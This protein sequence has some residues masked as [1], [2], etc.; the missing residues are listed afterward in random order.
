MNSAELDTLL[1]TLR[2]HGVRAYKSDLISVELFPVEPPPPKEPELP[3]GAPPELKNPD[4]MNE[5]AILNWSAPPGPGEEAQA[6]V[7]G[8]E[9]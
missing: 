4:L 2:K 1:S 5:D 6:P 8:E 7:A 3:P 9:P